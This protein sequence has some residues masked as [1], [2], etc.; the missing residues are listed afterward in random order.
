MGKVSL[1]LKDPGACHEQLRVRNDLGNSYDLVATFRPNTP[2]ADSISSHVANLA[3]VK[4]NTDA[5]ACDEHNF[6]HSIGKQGV[7]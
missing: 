1:D 2:Y 7:D 6:I 4:S 5:P 3:F